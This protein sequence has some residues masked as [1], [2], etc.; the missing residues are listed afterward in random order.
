MILV[1]AIE[2]NDGESAYV[3][4]RK[5]TGCKKK[6]AANIVTIFSDGKQILPLVKT[7]QRSNVDAQ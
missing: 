4:F 5:V 2:K 6:L 7:L 1:N 3:I